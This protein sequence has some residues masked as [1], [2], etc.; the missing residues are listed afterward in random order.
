MR[1]LRPRLSAR[2]LL[3][4]VFRFAC[5][6]YS[7]GAPEVP[8]RVPPCA[9]PCDWGM[10]NIRRVLGAVN[11]LVLPPGAATHAEA[12]ERRARQRRAGRTVQPAEAAEAAAGSGE[13]LQAWQRRDAQRRG[14]GA[15]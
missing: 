3:K 5:S 4:A 1:L 2:P 9:P 12:L 15:G 8:Q 7:T 10:R 11:R 14:P 6:S 13:A